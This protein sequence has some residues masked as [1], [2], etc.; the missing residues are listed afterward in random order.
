MD[1]WSQRNLVE[2]AAVDLA[3][4]AATVIKID[5]TVIKFIL[6]VNGRGHVVRITGR[7]VVRVAREEDQE[8][9]GGMMII[10]KKYG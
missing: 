2:E 7:G 3:N 9:A 10:E 1:A 6:P 5:T 4:A 8:E